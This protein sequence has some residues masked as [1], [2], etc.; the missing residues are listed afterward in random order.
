[1]FDF[2]TAVSGIEF[3]VRQLADEVTRLRKTVEG[4]SSLIVELEKAL[5]EK[6]KTVNKLTEENKIIKLGNRL[7]DGDDSTELKLKITQM[8]RVIDKSLDILK[9]T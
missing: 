2:E 8:I 4:Q 3:K 5:E 7:S 1:M 6:E 9:T